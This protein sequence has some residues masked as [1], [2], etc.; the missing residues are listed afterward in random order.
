MTERFSIGY[1]ICGVSVLPDKDLF[2]VGSSED[3]PYALPKD[4]YHWEWSK[5]GKAGIYMEC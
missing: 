2:V 5:E 4:D 1:D 3:L